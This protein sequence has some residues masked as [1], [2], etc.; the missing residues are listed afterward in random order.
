VVV[1]V[2]AA[3]VVVVAA[4]AAAAVVVEAVTVVVLTAVPQVG[5]RQGMARERYFGAWNFQN[6][7]RSVKHSPLVLP[8][9]PLLLL[10]RLLALPFC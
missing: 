4:A 9:S 3:A 2:A 1:V 6:R 10:L 8:P 5:R 7:R